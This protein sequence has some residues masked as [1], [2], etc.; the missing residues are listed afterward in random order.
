LAQTLFC[1]RLPQWLKVELLEF[2]D[3]SFMQK[4]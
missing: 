3:L 1:G 4:V 2:Q